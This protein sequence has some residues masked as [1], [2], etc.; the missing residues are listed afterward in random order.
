[1]M[2]FICTEK[3]FDKIYDLKNFSKIRVEGELLN[4][5]KGICEKL[6]LYLTVK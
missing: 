6:T 4:L 3:A 1:M 5:V 2:I